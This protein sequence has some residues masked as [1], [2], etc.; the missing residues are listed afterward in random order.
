MKAHKLIAILPEDTKETERKPFPKLKAPH[1]G[2]ELIDMAE[3]GKLKLRMVEL[4]K[5]RQ[6]AKFKAEPS[7]VYKIREWFK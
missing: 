2:I 5:K 1:Y 4:T 3:P 7:L 6:P